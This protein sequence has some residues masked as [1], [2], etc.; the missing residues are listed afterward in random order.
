[1][2]QTCSRFTDTRTPS[3]LSS[4]TVSATAT[5]SRQCVL[6]RAIVVWRCDYVAASVTSLISLEVI[7]LLRSA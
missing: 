1:M 4:L 7:E 5:V 2:Q 3:W 6:A